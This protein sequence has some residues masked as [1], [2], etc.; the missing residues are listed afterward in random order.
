MEEAPGRKTHR[1]ATTA[2]RMLG[3]TS[4]IDVPAIGWNDDD[5]PIIPAALLEYSILA[6]SKTSGLLRRPLMAPA[7]Q[8]PEQK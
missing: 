6:P 5:S 8:Y 3:L 7:K 4:G 2:Q 1:K